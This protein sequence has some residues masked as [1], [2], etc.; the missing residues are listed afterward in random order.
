VTFGA[1]LAGRTPWGRVLPYWLAQVIGGALATTVLLVVARSNSQLDSAT[2]ETLFKGGSNTFGEV[3]PLGFGLVGALVLETV[4]TG[5]FVAVILGT[6]A[7]DAHQS[8]A[9]PAIGLTLAFGLLI[10]TPV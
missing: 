3:S 8:L 7:R 9:A 2:V 6:T 1:A 10:L 5:I 4:V